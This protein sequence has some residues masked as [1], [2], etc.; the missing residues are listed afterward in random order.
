MAQDDATTTEA[1]LDD[2]RNE[3]VS[4]GF[5]IS[6]NNEEVTVYPDASG[7]EFGVVEHQYQGIPAQGTVLYDVVDWEIVD[8]DFETEHEDATM[9]EEFERY[10]DEIREWLV[11]ALFNASLTS[12]EANVYREERHVYIV[13]DPWD[14][15]RY[16][17]ELET[18][19]QRRVR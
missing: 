7:A 5:R 8:M 15:D 14:G 9:Q 12:A 3:A 6:S 13:E 4:A 16:T 10:E 2:L 1:T 18:E 17:I 11:D 19:N